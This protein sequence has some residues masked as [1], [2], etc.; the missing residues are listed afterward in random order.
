[1]HGGTIFW[2]PGMGGSSDQTVEQL[3]EWLCM[4]WVNNSNPKTLNLN[5]KTQHLGNLLRR[6]LYSRYRS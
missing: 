4:P 5:P 1:M 3:K 6:H 2:F